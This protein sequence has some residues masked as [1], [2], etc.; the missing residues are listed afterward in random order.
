MQDNQLFAIIIGLIT[1]Q[2][3]IAGVPGL[4]VKQA[5]QP[6]K[7]GT[8]LAPTVYMFKVFDERVGSSFRQDI[9]N[10]GTQE[11]DH[12]ETQQYASHFQL[13]AL[14]QQNPATPSQYTASDILNACAYIMQS[15]LTINTLQAQGVGVQRITPVRNPAFVDEHGQFAFQPNFDVILTHKQVITS[16]VP[17]LESTIFGVY[18]V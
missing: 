6:T 1:G 4:L 8:N 3:T 18:E 7:Q 17:V 15:S 5:Y 11:F 12:I 14:S 10:S 16:T 13:S 9:Y 2:A